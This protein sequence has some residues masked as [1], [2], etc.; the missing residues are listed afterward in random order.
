MRAL[1]NHPLLTGLSTTFAFA[2][3]AW[4]L[5]KYFPL[6]GG[7]VWG[8]LLGMLWACWQQ[9]ANDQSGINF[10]AK[11]I[12]QYSIILL[13]FEMNLQHIVSTGSQSLAIIFFTLSAAFLTAWLAG[14][15][16]RVS[17]PSSI[18]IGVGTA[19]CGGS[20]IAAA[21]P[22]IRA[23]EKDVAYS[24]STIFL[25]N[26]AA[27]FIFP[28]LGHAMQLSDTGFG[29]WA[30]T[31]INDTSSVV[32]AGYSYSQNAGSFATIVKLTR[33]LMIIPVTLVL[34]LLTARKQQLD[35]TFSFT[36]TFPWFILGFVL[37]SVVHTLGML[38]PELCAWL[39]QAGKFLIIVA[40]VGIGLKTSLPNLI[41]NGLRPVLLGLACWFAVAVVSLIVQHYLQIW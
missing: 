11:K 19:I 1:I 36:K 17:D 41:S 6:I 25:F 21:A 5:G 16:L 34:S 40:M 38:P 4:L 29:M 33:T 24:I 20:A 26:I 30:G 32:A 18:L 15:Y 28:L 8:I 2:L 3:P 9:P 27:V 22:A 35:Q 39:A 7:P 13:G 10:A 23:G 37:A 31:A 14:K 12:L